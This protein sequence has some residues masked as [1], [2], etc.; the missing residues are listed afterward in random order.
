ME[1]I[2]KVN[3]ASIKVNLDDQNSVDETMRGLQQNSAGLEDGLNSGGA[4]VT[5]KVRLIKILMEFANA[6]A[7]GEYSPRLKDSKR[8]IEKRMNF[9]INGNGF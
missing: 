9:V 6:T 4:I 5:T 2:S 1:I 7:N 8:F 3:S